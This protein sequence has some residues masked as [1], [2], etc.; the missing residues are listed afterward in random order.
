MATA[1]KASET[2]AQITFGVHFSLHCEYV[3]LVRCRNKVHNAKPKPLE[4][5]FILQDDHQEEAGKDD[6]IGG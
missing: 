2:T 6:D 3:S 1:F 5:S 4:L